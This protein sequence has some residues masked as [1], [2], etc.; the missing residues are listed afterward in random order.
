V[1]IVRI[2]TSRDGKRRV[3][4]VDRGGGRFGYDEEYF[5]DVP[6]ERAGFHGG[7]FR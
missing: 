3:L 5:S 7:R 4:V 6:N 1:T 2:L